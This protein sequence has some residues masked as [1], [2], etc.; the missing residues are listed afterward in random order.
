MELLEA[1]TP[2]SN[3]NDDRLDK[4]D[5]EVKEGFVRLE[6]QMERLQGHMNEGFAEMRSAYAALTPTLLVGAIAIV[7]ALI[8]AL[9]T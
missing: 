5:Q 8:G 2:M 4:R 3:W 1:E 9:L 7:A 6:R